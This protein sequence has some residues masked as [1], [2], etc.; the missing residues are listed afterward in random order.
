M[1]EPRAALDA[2][3]FARG[4]NDTRGQPLVWRDPS[5]PPEAGG[6]Y[7]FRDSFNLGT[8]WVAPVDVAIDQGPLLL[9]IENA[10]TGLI[11]RVF[12]AHPWVQDAANRLGW[13]KP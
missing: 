7:G 13:Q 11:W 3:R 10:R 8:G 1:F 6:G 2:L 4:L 5:R 9:A 12:H